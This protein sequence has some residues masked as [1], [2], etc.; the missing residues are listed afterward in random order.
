LI[1]A[2]GKDVDFTNATGVTN[3]SLYSLF[4]QYNVV[5]LNG[6]N[7]TQTSENYHCR[8]CLETLMTYGTYAVAT[9]LSNSNPYMDT[10]DM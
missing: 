6:D 10:D 7:I 9:N 1:S 5:I 3:N 8:L 2:A 4:N